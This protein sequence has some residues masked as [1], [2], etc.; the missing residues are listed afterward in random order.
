MTKS[1]RSAQVTLKPEFDK[2]IMFKAAEILD[3]KKTEKLFVQ[4]GHYM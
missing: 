4:E 3:F 2:L 1:E